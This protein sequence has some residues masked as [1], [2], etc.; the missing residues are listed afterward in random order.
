MSLKSQIIMIDLY[1][2][3]IKCSTDFW[4]DLYHCLFYHYFK[5]CESYSLIS[6]LLRFLLWMHAPEMGAAPIL[7]WDAHTLSDVNGKRSQP[8]H[9]NL[10]EALYLHGNPVDFLF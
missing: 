3:N 4:S 5:K 7:K 1:A 2:K 10:N 6:E 9:V 8:V